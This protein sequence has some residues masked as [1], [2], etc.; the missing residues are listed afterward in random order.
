M[1]IRFHPEAELEIS[2]AI[3]WYE[4][5]RKG[6]GSE[7]LICIDEAIEKI[8]RVPQLF[9]LVHRNIRRVVVRRFPFAVFYEIKE[10][11]IRVLAVFHSRRDPE[12][13]KKRK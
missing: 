6:L 10:L 11:E 13:W 5:Q 1:R 3:Q 4:Y 2:D 12:I 8:K 7:F 9:P